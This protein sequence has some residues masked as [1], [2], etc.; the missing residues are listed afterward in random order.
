MLSGLMAIV[1]TWVALSSSTD[2]GLLRCFSSIAP[3]FGDLCFRITWTCSTFHFRN[4][5]F[6]S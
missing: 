2:G 4:V 5:A 3:L 6:V 1:Y